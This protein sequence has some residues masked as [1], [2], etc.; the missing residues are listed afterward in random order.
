M[1][2]A[3]CLATA[4]LFLAVLPALAHHAFSAEFDAKNPIRLEGTVYSS[5]ILSNSWFSFWQ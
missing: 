4:G 3:A 5:E 2:L 1:K